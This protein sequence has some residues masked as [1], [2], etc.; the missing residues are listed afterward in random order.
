MLNENKMSDVLS[1]LRRGISLR[2]DEIV[3]EEMEAAKIRADKRMVEAVAALS[4]E[5][6]AWYT[7]R[8]LGT[9]ISIQIEKKRVEGKK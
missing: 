5:F 8:D 9:T 2:M 4:L 1:E 6:A 3:Q 7:M